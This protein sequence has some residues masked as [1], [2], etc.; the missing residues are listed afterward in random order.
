MEDIVRTVLGNLS[1]LQPFSTSHYTVFPYKKRWGVCGHSTNNLNLYPFTII[2]YVEKNMHRGKQTQ[3]NMCSVSCEP[4]R[5]CCRRDSPLEEAILQDLIND[6]EVQHNVS[7]ASKVDSDKLH[8]DREVDGDPADTPERATWEP[9]A[10]MAG[11][12]ERPAVDWE[13]PETAQDPEEQEGAT[14]WPGIFRRLASILPF[15]FKSP[16]NEC[17]R[18][19]ADRGMSL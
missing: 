9:S 8:A 15:L 17:G 3:E 1:N 13:M 6:M 10:G 16:E 12:K 19:A 2:V 18:K 14:V 7:A 11:P 4:Q 5:K